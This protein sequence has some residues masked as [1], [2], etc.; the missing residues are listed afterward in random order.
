MTVSRNAPRIAARVEQAAALY[1]P[2]GRFAVQFARG[3]LAGDP[4]FATLLARRVIPDTGRLV[5][6]GCGQG[7][8]AAWMT[9]GAADVDHYLGIDRSAKD[10][11][12]ARRALPKFATFAEAD[13]RTIDAD[14]IGAADVVTLFDVLHYLAPD[15]QERLLSLV[16]GSLR[17]GG[18]LLLRVGDADAKCASRWADVVDRMVCAFRGMPAG[19]LHRRSI[20]DWSALLDHLGFDVDRIEPITADHRFANVLLRAELR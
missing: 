16:R 1:R 11:E 4:L 2:S 19:R 17:P 12:R 3:K 13:L 20:D 7:L 15:A 18:L 10:L 5:D 6:L 14:A 9:T 8:L